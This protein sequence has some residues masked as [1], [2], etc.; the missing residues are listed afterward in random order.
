MTDDDSINNSPIWKEKNAWSI[1]CK[2]PDYFPIAKH[3]V[4]I[5]LSR[6]KIKYN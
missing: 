6:I 3:D 4:Y 1:S 5:K 2:E